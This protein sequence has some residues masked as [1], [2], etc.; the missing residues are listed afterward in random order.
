MLPSGRGENDTGLRA[1]T[2]DVDKNSTKPAKNL[3]A[4]FLVASEDGHEM[5]TYRVSFLALE[6]EEI[7]RVEVRRPP[8]RFWDASTNARTV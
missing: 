3:S 6:L 7:L 2:V 8:C 4:S 1:S 5:I